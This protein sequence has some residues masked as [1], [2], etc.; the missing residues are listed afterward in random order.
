MPLNSADLWGALADILLHMFI[1]PFEYPKSVAM[2]EKIPITTRFVDTRSTLLVRPTRS[3]TL[4]LDPTLSLIYDL[5]Y[6][7]GKISHRRDN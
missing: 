2:M 1:P 7:Q 6:R 5:I 4:A 3:S